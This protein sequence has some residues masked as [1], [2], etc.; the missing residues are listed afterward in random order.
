MNKPE[1]HHPMR[2]EVSTSPTWPGKRPNRPGLLDDETMVRFLTAIRGGNHRDVSARF[3]GLNP[4]TVQEW[5][6]RARGKRPDRPPGPEHIRFLRL[7]EEA[8]AAQEVQATSNLYAL[9]RKDFNAVR[10]YLQKKYPKRWGDDAEPKDDDAAEA[11]PQVVVSQQQVI[12]IGTDVIEAIA[13]QRLAERRRELNPGSDETATETPDGPRYT[14][15]DRL[16]SES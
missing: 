16:R 4:E 10:F 2:G 15:L 8:E 6:Q 11:T 13:R 5:I 14:A 3:V 12:M 1:A 9:T 7:V